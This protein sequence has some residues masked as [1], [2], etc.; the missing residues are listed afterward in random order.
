MLKNR[1]TQRINRANKAVRACLFGKISRDTLHALHRRSPT[2]DNRTNNQVIQLLDIAKNA[3]EKMIENFCISQEN[4]SKD[5]CD[6]YATVQH[7]LI[8]NAMSNKED[9]DSVKSISRF[10]LDEDRRNMYNQ[11]YNLTLGGK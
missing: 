8:M 3:N 11:L 10:V 6:K 2:T 5:L 9:L 4:V 1:D 7:N